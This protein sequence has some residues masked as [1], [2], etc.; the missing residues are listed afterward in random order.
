LRKSGYHFKTSSE[1]EIVRQIKEKLSYVALNPAKEEK[2]AAARSEEYVLPDGG[3]VKVRL[4][5]E[6]HKKKRKVW[7]LVSFSSSS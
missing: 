1:K 2:E 4:D 7:C 5:S 3:I 6:T